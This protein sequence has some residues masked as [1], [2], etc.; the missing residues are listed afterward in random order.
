MTGRLGIDWEELDHANKKSLART[1]LLYL[2]R[3]N[4]VE[5]L[6]GVLRGDE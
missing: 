5:E 2:Y 3:R 1:L 6:V 4:R